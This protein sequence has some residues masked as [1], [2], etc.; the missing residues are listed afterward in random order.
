MA[1]TTENRGYNKLFQAWGG[2]YW[3]VA[4]SVTFQYSESNP[5][6]TEKQIVQA[7]FQVFP[8]ILPCW[9][10]GSHFRE[11]IQESPLTDAVLQNRES[12][13]RWLHA[14]HN[15]VNRGLRKPEISYEDAKRFYLHD[16]RRGRLPRTPPLQG[17]SAAYNNNDIIK[18]IMMGVG[19]VLGV[20]VLAVGAVALKRKLKKA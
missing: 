1:M 15:K 9:R 18:K 3:R 20:G 4:H 19:I 8:D 11:H 10:C 2:D 16:A 5:S 12:L 14:I 6:D 17:A 13:S 7:F